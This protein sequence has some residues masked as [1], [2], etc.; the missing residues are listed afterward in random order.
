MQRRFG[1]L[2]MLG[3]RTKLREMTGLSD[4]LW[5]LGQKHKTE[6]QSEG[7][8]TVVN[9]QELQGMARFQLKQEVEECSS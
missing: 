9:L 4:M 7:V 8:A 1:V 5:N 2:G 6:N 3:S